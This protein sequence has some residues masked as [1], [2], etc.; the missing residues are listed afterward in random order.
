[1][2]HFLFNTLNAVT[3][4]AKDGDAAAV[5]RMLTLLSGLL[6]DVL[7]TDDV[8]LIPLSSELAFSRQYLE[9]ELV[10][11]A[12]RLR[13]SE[14][15]DQETEQA[16]VPV[17]ILQ[18]LIENALRHGLAPRASGGT[19]TLHARKADAMLEL[20]VRDDGVG[21]PAT[22][23]NDDDCYGIGLTNVSARLRELYAGRATM[24]VV[25]E[26]AGGTCASIRLPLS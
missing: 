25:R 13:I 1:H 19:I 8:Q 10:R 12:D 6:R 22:W 20:A 15:I 7:R 5:A 23:G 9:I 18:P 14:S 26:S 11:F 17:F 3:V 16:L 4:L 21:L 24:T 2:P